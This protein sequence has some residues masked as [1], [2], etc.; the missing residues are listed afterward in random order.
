MSDLDGLLNNNFILFALGLIAARIV[1][2]GEKRANVQEQLALVRQ[3]VVDL[4]AW[5]V[6]HNSIHGCVKAMQ[7]ALTG[8]IAEARTAF[9][10][11]HEENRRLTNRL[12]RQIDQ[13]MAHGPSRRATRWEED[14][15]LWER[16]RR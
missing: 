1:A 12:E 13:N 9:R 3:E 7:V 5:Q 6:E 4:K 10:E 8:F 2:W 11:L 16:T 14:E 15:A